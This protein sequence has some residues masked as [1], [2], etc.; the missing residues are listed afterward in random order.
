ML[1]PQPSG[2][3]ASLERK[4][5]APIIHHRALVALTALFVGGVSDVAVSDECYSV[6]EKVASTLKQFGTDIYGI[7]LRNGQSARYIIWSVRI[8][9]TLIIM[10][11][12]LL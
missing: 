7:T 2:I 12:G 11:H 3:T 4:M 9:A 1:S 8:L 10:F 5:N 6:G